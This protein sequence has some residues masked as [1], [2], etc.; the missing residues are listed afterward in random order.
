LLLDGKGGASN[1]EISKIDCGTG[2]DGALWLHLDINNPQ[3]VSWLKQSSQLDPLILDALLAEET[4]PRTTVI[5][6]DLLMA[7]RGVNLTPGAEPD[8]MVSIR[9]WVARDC[10]I[11]TRRR[12]LLSVSDI[13]ERLDAGLG[14][15]SASEFIVD[16]IDGLVWRMSSTV[17]NLE[18]LVADME[19]RGLEGGSSELRFELATLRRQAIT[20]RRYL[21]PQ[22]EALGRL[23][24]EKVS[25]IDDGLRLRLRE[26][27]D[28]L[29]RHIED[30][31]AVRERAS[32]TQE[33][34]MGRLSEQMN[35]RM[36]VLSIAAAIFLPLGF[37][38]GLLGV[39]LGGIPGAEN[40][41][42]FWVFVVVIVLVVV[43]MAVLFRW[44]RWL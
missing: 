20:L 2:A 43:L 3:H 32:V 12:N 35:N 10:I 44:K 23:I 16:L 14:P 25:W 6:D 9:L 13:I 38:T 19:G 33:E 28:R 36:Y 21:A 31:D 7:L 8:D 40:T 1:I 30:L 41:V 15:S 18:D 27:G 37:L 42:A 11:S 39:N 24:V 22:R 29:T 17:D 5:G 4:R 26:V 34:L